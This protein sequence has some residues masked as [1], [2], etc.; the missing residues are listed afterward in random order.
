MEA[1]CSPDTSVDFHGTARRYFPEERNI[2]NL[3]L[4]SHLRLDLPGEL[5]F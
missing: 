5:F 4:F 2:I 1:V 3:I